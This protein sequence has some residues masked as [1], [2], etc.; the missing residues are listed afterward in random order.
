MRKIKVY[1]RV[2]VNNR[3]V[4]KILKMKKKEIKMKVN[5][6]KGRGK[7]SKGENKKE[8]KAKIIALANRLSEK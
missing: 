3:N 6:K 4:Q 8:I 2:G 5:L 7:T 1:S